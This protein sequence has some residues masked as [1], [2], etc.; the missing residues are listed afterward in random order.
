MNIINYDM[1]IHTEYCGH[2]PQMTVKALCGRADELGLE[3]IAITDHIFAPEDVYVI[4]R[5]REE[6]ART[7]HRCRVIIGAEIDVDSRYDDGRLVTEETDGIDYLI[8][9]FHYVPTV[10]NYPFCPEDCSLKP[11]QFL[12]HWRNALLGVVSN[13]KVNTLAHPG[14]LALSAIGPDS[15]FIEILAAFKAAAKISAKNKVAWEINELTGYRFVDH[16]LKRWPAIY[17]IALDAGVK[18]SYGSDA[19]AP[20]TI[21][22]A[23]FTYSLL[24]ELG[25]EKLSK[26][27][28]LIKQKPV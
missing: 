1:H 20:E 15:C 25:P 18:L 5:I 7:E 21:G 12:K 23:D 8:A 9:G 19:H 11:K 2:A 14:R 28:E 13:P 10:G 26:P 24:D 22:L 16:Y 27:A 4:D 6:L 3:T 17:R